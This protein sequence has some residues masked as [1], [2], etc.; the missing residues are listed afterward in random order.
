[1][2]FSPDFWS[3]RCHIMG[4]WSDV[5]I[6]SMGLSSSVCHASNSGRFSRKAKRHERFLLFLKI[7]RNFSHCF[8]II[9]IIDLIEDQNYSNWCILEMVVN[10]AFIHLSHDS[11][12]KL[13][14]ELCEARPAH[15]THF[16]CIKAQFVI[17]LGI[18]LRD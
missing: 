14:D 17:L 12:F 16:E 7:R 1:M 8:W 11:V 5:D 3:V 15:L 6:W 10:T 9:G 4:G 13:R 18:E 2:M